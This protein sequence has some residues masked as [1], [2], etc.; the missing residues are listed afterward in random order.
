MGGSLFVALALGLIWI[1]N[2]DDESTPSSPLD[3]SSTRPRSHEARGSREL[4][5][6]APVRA[7][8]PGARY[9]RGDR[10]RAVVEAVN[11]PDNAP[12]DAASERDRLEQILSESGTEALEWHAD[13]RELLAQR[14]NNL[15]ITNISNVRCFR[16]GCLVDVLYRDITEYEQ[17]APIRQEIEME[18]SWPGI[19]ISTGPSVSGDIVSTSWIL[20]APETM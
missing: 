6:P 17:M 9:Q 3:S 2:K 5:A 8:L 19:T 1:S 18:E 7:D 15:G 14:A 10:G 16:D 13:A 20:L 11:T 12:L 4:E